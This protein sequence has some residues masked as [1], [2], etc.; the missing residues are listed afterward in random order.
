MMLD[1]VA[2]KQIWSDA[3]APYAAVARTYAVDQ[4]TPISAFLRLRPLGA[5]TLL[6]SVEGDAKTARYSFV[7]LGEWARLLESQGQA[8]LVG[9]EGTTVDSDPLVL[10][11][12]QMKRQRVPV[13]DHID[14][15]FTG[16]AIGYFGY[17][18]VRQLEHLPSP[19][20]ETGGPLWEWVWPKAVAAFDHHKQTLTLIVESRPQE[21]EAAA[22]RLEIL[23]DALRQPAALAAPVTHKVGDETI[24]MDRAYYHQMIERAKAYIMQ[25]DIFQVVLSRKFSVKIAGDAFGLYRKLRRE[26]PSPYLF[27]LETQRRTL[28]GASPEALVRV[29]NGHVSN[30]PIAGTRPR[31][32]T[33]EDDN[34]LWDDLIRDPKE[35]AEH[36]MLV[37]LA[38][39]DVGRVSRYG[40]V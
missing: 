28:V 25:G 19:F 9:P 29:Q 23:A 22:V 15:P 10:M 5:H 7:A 3:S 39:N 30:R 17:D 18:W 1:P 27:Y 14:L 12:Q 21:I 34:R 31:G 36:V 16:G 8:V 2:G 4:L 35:R 24:N 26:N 11:R 38:R 40:T 32:K 37:D 20:K 13:P 6:E 33:A